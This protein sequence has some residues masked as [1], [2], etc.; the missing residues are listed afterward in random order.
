MENVISI[1]IGVIAGLMSCKMIRKGGFGV[2]G[3]LIIAVLGAMLGGW[4]SHFLGVSEG[5]EELITCIATS[6]LGAILFIFT[7]VSLQQITL[8]VKKETVRYLKN[9]N[10]E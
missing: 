3:N 2:I 6:N 10:N 8:F 9:K 1:V 4:F 5:N 7:A